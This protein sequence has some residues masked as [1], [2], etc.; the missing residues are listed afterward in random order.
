MS[1]PDGTPLADQMLA[2]LEAIANKEPEPYIPKPVRATRSDKIEFDE[3]QV[4][5]IRMMVASGLTH[6]EVCRIKGISADTL[7]RRAKENPDLA[8]AL[9]DG[10]NQATVAMAHAV[11]RAANK[12]DMRAA[13]FWLSRRGG[14]AWKE[15][16]IE[17]TGKD[18]GPIQLQ[19]V[20]T[21]I[22]N[23]TPEQQRAWLEQ[24]RK[25]DEGDDSDE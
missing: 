20:A 18:G 6:G 14:D 15:K 5:E 9:E 11:F 16:P 2:T 21:E 25:L 10:Q 17:I 8:A 13:T 7:R 19:A 24:Q 23:M 1:D 4:D 22:A 3:K 12:G